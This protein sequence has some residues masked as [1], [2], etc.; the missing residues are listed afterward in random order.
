M[1]ICCIIEVKIIIMHLRETDERTVKLIRET[2]DNDRAETMPFADR[3]QHLPVGLC[4]GRFVR[5]VFMLRVLWPLAYL[6]GSHVLRR[7]ISNIRS[8][9]RLA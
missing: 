9:L 4:C 3:E 2:D 8:E 5:F 1:V 6:T 7:S